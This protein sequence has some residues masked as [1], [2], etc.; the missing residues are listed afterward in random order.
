MNP[1]LALIRQ[2]EGFRETPYWDVNA[3]RT[4][5]GSDT[6]TLA[7]GSV[8]PVGKNTRVTRE[9]AD[10]DLQR[11]VETEFMPRAA[12]AIGEETFASL[13]PSQQAALVSI[14]YNYG[15]LPSSVARA[16]QSGNPAA[17]A[18]AIRA[19]GSH[20]DGI[21]RDRRAK[22]AD[23]FAGTSALPVQSGMEADGPGRVDRNPSR[24]AWARANGRMTPEDAALYDQG[25]AEGQ[26][27]K[28]EKPQAPA[29]PDPLAIYAATAM[30][31]RQPFQ[32][33]ALNAMPVQNA[34][35]F[36]RI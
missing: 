10:R 31:P 14:T 32:P 24:L 34:T 2:F 20:N 13:S 17:A 3:L 16:V 25:V 22:E 11:R 21:N 7:D 5:Y 15:E 35:P 23:V 28:A 8:V 6:V 27:P 4:G 9:D 30:R 36:G 12:R 29:Q 19:L 33:V 1:T 26:F 18:E